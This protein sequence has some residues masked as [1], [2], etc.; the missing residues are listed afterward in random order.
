MDMFGMDSG[1]VESALS[2]LGGLMNTI[3]N[4]IEQPIK[5]MVQQVLGGIWKGKGADAFVEMINNQVMGGVTKVQGHVGNYQTHI[6]S[7]VDLINA[8]DMKAAQATSP[9]DESFNF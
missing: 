4:E 7:T 9:L 5:A 3:T 6:N 1:G 2:G 8:G